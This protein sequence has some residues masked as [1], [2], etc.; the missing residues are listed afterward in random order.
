MI[1]NDIWN[2][3]GH[4]WT[5][6]DILVSYVTFD[7]LNITFDKLNIIEILKKLYWYS[8]ISI[9]SEMT[10]IENKI[11]QVKKG[12]MNKPVKNEKSDC[13]K[14]NNKELKKQMTK[15]SIYVGSYG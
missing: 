11:A 8:F 9:M 14:L 7:K 6:G 4:L 12:E 2:I 1:F 13:Q 5:V 15:G 10:K 3:L